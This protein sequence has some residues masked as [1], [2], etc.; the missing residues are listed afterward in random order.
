MHLVTAEH[1]ANIHAHTRSSLLTI[2]KGLTFQMTKIGHFGKVFSA[3]HLG[4]Y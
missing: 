3:S 2:L 1:H 4:Q